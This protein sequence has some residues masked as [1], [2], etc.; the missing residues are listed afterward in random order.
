[1][2]IRIAAVSLCLTVLCHTARAAC[3]G[4]CGNDG[5][6]TIDE[7]LVGINIALGNT[8]PSECANFDGN[9]DSSV[10][11]D[12]LITAINNALS[13]CPGDFAGSYE[14]HPPLSFDSGHTGT[15]N[16]SATAEGL[17]IGSLLVT[18]VAH[19]FSRFAPALSFTF[20]VGGVSVSL[21]GAYGPN[22]GFE[23]EGA[24]VDANGQ[25]T[26]V[27]ISGTLPGLT[28]DAPVNVYIGTDR[29]STTL[30]A[31]PIATP[32]PQPTPPPGNGPRIVFAEGLPSHIS[33]I[34]IDGSGKTQL[35]NPQGND[36]T[37]AWSPDGTTIAFATPDTN[38]D[39]ITIGVMN[40]DG[41]GFA[42]LTEDSAFLDGNPAWSPNGAQIVFTAGG[43]D[44]VDI[45]N[46]DG[47]GRQR[48]V[49]QTAGETYGHL[50]WSPNGSKIAF[51]STRPRQAGSDSRFEIWV[52][53]PDGTG[54]V[55]LTNNDFPD[56]HP[57][58]SPHGSKIAFE[59]QHP[60]SGRY[61]YVMS[62]DGS[63][64]TQ[65]THGF[66]GDSRPA[67]SRDG[68]RIAYAT[69]PGIVIAN[70]DGSNPT[71]VPNTG[72]LADFDFR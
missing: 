58:W 68:S 59:S 34:N 4:D 40:A 6:V 37:P 27:V 56:E 69:I 38:N 32:T 9:S 44:A 5:T 26:S 47:S 50:S 2:R 64:Q 24:F 51:E 41:S 35:T 1:M 54:L 15:I 65:L 36:S 70:A 17:V 10:T 16:L 53:N 67:W 72:P 21:S 57:A 23:V 48:L 18:D 33:V 49:T 60:F 20:P 62:P 39:H 66:F 8:E 61:I 30:S 7:L 45:M 52:M 29:F 71:T 55:Q 42:R 13:G 63:G 22:G 25:T 43:G 14:S 3:L 12:E 31:A 46:A 11:V 19:A 28:G